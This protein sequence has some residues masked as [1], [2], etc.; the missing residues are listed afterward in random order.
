M[1]NLTDKGISLII[2]R[3][4]NPHNY[5]RGQ[6]TGIGRIPIFNPLCTRAFLQELRQI[7]ISMPLQR[8]SARQVSQ[9]S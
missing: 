1:Q 4:A 7:L 5:I 8:D 6:S 2:H 3:I 9:V